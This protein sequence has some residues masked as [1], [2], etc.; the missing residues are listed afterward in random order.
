MANSTNTDVDFGSLVLETPVFEDGLFTAGGAGTVKKG[1]ILA[2]HSGTLKFIAFVKGGSSNG[3]GTP[4][5]VLPADLEATGAT[6]FPTRALVR[7]VVN[8]KRLV[9]A[10]D[11]DDSN[12]DAAVRDQLRSFG[13]VPVDVDQ[14][15][16]ASFTDEDS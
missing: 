3:N 8:K 2:R 4:V 5:A 13:I 15:D 6:D 16:G 14:H 1:T 7:G 11:G 10:A 9:I 12:V